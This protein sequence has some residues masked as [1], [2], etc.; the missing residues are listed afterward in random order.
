MFTHFWPILEAPKKRGWHFFFSFLHGLL[1]YLPFLI[2][3]KTACSDI[4][5]DLTE[6]PLIEQLHIH[7]HHDAEITAILFPF[8]ELDGEMVGQFLVIA[9]VYTYNISTEKQH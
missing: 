8:L 6:T 2:S 1:F 7:N 5:L 9:F 3:A 4:G